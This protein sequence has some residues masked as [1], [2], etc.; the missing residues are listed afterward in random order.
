MFEA[1][2]NAKTFRWMHVHVGNGNENE[3]KQILHVPSI[4]V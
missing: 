3:F 2:F 1:H 4:Q